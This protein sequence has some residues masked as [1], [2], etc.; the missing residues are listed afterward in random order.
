[1]SEYHN[2]QTAM[3]RSR[4]SAP[5]RILL[6]RELIEGEVLDFG[7]GRGD[8]VRFLSEMTNLTVVG[9]DPHWCPHG[10]HIHLGQ[11]MGA[12]RALETPNYKT[13]LCT[14]VLNVVPPLAQMEIVREV[15]RLLGKGGA[16]FFTVRRDIPQEGTDTQWWVKQEMFDESLK[17]TG[18]QAYPVHAVLNKYDIYMVEEI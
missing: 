10:I 15:V 2:W 13:I 3:A 4:L 5:V 18:Y 8:D 16:A 6:D 17:G 11:T 7:C 14:Y 1:M 9:W 12:A